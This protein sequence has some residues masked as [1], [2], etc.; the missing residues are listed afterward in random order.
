MTLSQEVSKIVNFFIPEGK[1][2]QWYQTNNASGIIST[3]QK[4]EII[5]FLLERVDTLEKAKPVT[6]TP[7]DIDSAIQGYFD[8]LLEDAKSRVVVEKAQ[9]TSPSDSPDTESW[10]DLQLRAKAA[11][12]Y[13]VG[14]KKEEL[15]NMLEEYVKTHLQPAT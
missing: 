2:R 8:R 10:L 4:D 7:L 1:F 3:K 12:I 5:F 9:I 15:K 11:G 13:K 14:V 6:Q